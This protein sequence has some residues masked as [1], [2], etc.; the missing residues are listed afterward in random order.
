LQKG[1]QHATRH[2]IVSGILCQSY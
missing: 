1:K 2:L